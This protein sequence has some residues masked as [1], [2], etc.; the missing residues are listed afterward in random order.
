MLTQ[1]QVAVLFKEYNNAHFKNLEEASA[2]FFSNPSCVSRSMNNKRPL[3]K[4]MLKALGYKKK[5]MY[6]KIDK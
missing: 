6:E 4:H 2:A 5:I 3:S 1:E